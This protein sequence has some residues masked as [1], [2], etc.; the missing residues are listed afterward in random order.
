M[1]E[2]KQV[3]KLSEGLRLHEVL[4]EVYGDLAKPGTKQVGKALGTVFEF[5]NT[6]LLP[7]A[8]ANVRS[9]V[10]REN[11]ERYRVKM[12]YTPEEDVCEVTAELGVPIEE[13]LSY[14]TNEQLREMYIVLLAKASHFQTVNVAH[15][16]FVN[17]INNISPD[18]AILMKS[19]RT[20]PQTP[21]VQVRLQKKDKNE[22]IVVDPLVAALSCLKNLS[23]PN[24]I[25]AYF[26][27][28]EGLGVL[29]TSTDTFLVG[30]NIYGPL[31]ALAKLRYSAISNEHPDYELVFPQ[32]IIN[33]TPFG[34]LFLEACF[35]PDIV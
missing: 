7:L 17:I 29:Y 30:D 31:E 10:L 33:I 3:A 20:T 22:Y 19:L 14:V 11:L 32:R 18:E 34:R 21:F 9:R 5:G 4:R 24:N 27:N 23:F 15:P 25:A 16:S 6:L 35:S 1:E 2:L 13:K 28:L 8:F 26:S 12:Q